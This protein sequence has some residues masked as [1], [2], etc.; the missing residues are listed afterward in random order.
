MISV[1]LDGR[2]V[3]NRAEALEAF[4]PYFPDYYGRNLDALWDCLTEFGEAIEI[5]LVNCGELQANLGRFWG[6]LRTVLTEAG[7]ENSMI[8]IAEE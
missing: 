6:K 3:K 1:V 5:R 4:A 8:F 7:K 2:S